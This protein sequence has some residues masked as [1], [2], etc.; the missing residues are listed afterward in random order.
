MHAITDLHVHPSLKMFLWPHLK[1]RTFRQRMI[2]GPFFNPLSFRTQ[3]SYLQQSPMRVMVVAHYVV[4]QDFLRYGLKPWASLVARTGMPRLF[5]SDPWQSFQTM[6]EILEDAVKNTNE[7]RQSGDKTLRILRSSAELDS[8]RDDEIGMIHAAEGSNFLGLDRPEGMDLDAYWQRTRERL[9]R[10]KEWGVCMITPAHFW[11]TLFMPQTEGTEWVPYK[12]RG[13]I[14]RKRD[15]GLVHMK[16]ATWH[17]GDPGTLAEPFVR[18]CMELGMLVDISH[19]QEHAR[20]KIYELAREY[21]RPVVASHV[22]L[23]SMF[24]HEYNLSD[25]EVKAI[26]GVGGVIGIILSKRLLLPPEQRYHPKADGIKDVLTVADRILNL[27]GDLSS[28]AIGTDFDGFT[29]PM[30]DV[31]NAGMLNGLTQAIYDHFGEEGGKAITHGNG[32]RALKQGWT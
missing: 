14:G 32:V 19:T 3:F 11:D 24:N 10:C 4:E 6:M 25:E 15:D 22:G 18:T 5:E 20:W 12:S 7:H 23:K 2:S 17:W 26:H 28:I 31:Y 30:K 29:D 8:V 21:H 27:T 9:Q 1:R 13:V 16:R